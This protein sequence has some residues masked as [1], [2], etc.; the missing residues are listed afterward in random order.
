[1]QIVVKNTMQ[2]LR[3]PPKLTISEWADTYRKLSPE[4]SAESGSWHTSRCEYQREI[5][6]TFNDVNIERIVVMT[7]SQV[8]KTEI[9]LNAIGYYIDQDSSPMMVVQPNLTMGQAFS[10][11]RLAAMIRDSDRL[12]EVV[13]DAKSRDSGNT[14]MHKK[15]P[16]GHITIS[17]SGSPAG[18]A[19]RPIRCLFL[20][21]I[22]RF[23]HNVKG[24]GSP[25]SL[26]IARTKTFFNRKIFMCS[27][28]TIKGISAIESAFEESDKRY[29]NVPCPECNYKQ[30]LKW[31]NLVW[32]EDKPDTA[33]YACEDCGSLIEESSKQWMINNGEWI[34]TNQINKTAGFHISELYS[35]WSTWADMAFAFLEAKKNPETLK[36]FI[37]TSLGESWEEQGDGVEHEGLLARRLNY[38]GLTLPEDIL[39]ATCAVDCQ[40]DRLEAMTVGWGHNYQ[41]WVIEH[42][43]FWGDPN[44]VNVW[45]EL[46]V[47]L[48][49]R[50][51]TE[52]GRVISISS[53]CID[54]GGHH[55][56]RVYSF[57]KPRQGRRI[58]A[59]KGASVPGKP[60][61]SKPTYVGKLQNVL[62]SVGTDTAKE[63]IFAR[64]NAPVDE[65]TLHFPADV[66]EEFFLQLT[67]EKRITKWI[68][69]RKAL[70]WKQ[71]RPRNEILDLLVYNFAAIYLLNP[72]FD[73]IEERL[74]TGAKEPK[75][76]DESN[77]LIRRNNRPNSN[78]ANSWKDL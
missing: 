76:Q 17:S 25:I 63:N 8:G 40:K 31:K 49:S 28:P 13:S 70:A 45:N 50:F 30:V 29:Y 2:K 21:E 36:T 77:P 56:Q 62:Y 72:N 10:K 1:M 22:D 69:G 6:D 39:V 41:S 44:A 38:D 55:T 53:T 20:D 5:M 7:S 19:S 15:F 60:I 9:L 66:D 35:V 64:L 23:E 78:F 47:Y 24:E 16:G 67:A 48:K 52:S 26:A 54:S 32:D 68:R 3:P 71:I 57:T 73:V 4:S 14:T 61:V 42:K 12:R 34:S 46:D 37:N 75:P 43:V 74:L 58:F 59:I 27:T 11:D 51:K 33:A 18:L 65:T